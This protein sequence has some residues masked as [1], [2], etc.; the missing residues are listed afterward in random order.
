MVKSGLSAESKSIPDTGA[1]IN[2]A[3]RSLMRMMG[4]GPENLHKNNQ[5]CMAVGNHPLE[6]LGFL[7]VTI[8][9]E[10]TDGKPR[11]TEGVIYFAEDVKTTLVSLTK[12]KDLG[13][14]P[15]YWPQ[16]PGESCRVLG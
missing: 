9:T 13:S 6:M 3:R 5:K 4:L 16:P 2:L 15:S 12:L 11:S 8:S 10:D 7:P 14:V 1:E